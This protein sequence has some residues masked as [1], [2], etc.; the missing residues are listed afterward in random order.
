MG[1]LRFLLALSVVIIHSAP[2]LG[3]QLVSGTS[4]VQGFFIVSGF[5]M[6][7]ILNE[8]YPASANGNWLFYS[9]RFLR[10]YP[11]YWVTLSIAVLV[12]LIFPYGIIANWKMAISNYDWSTLLYLVVS[13]LTLIG[14]DLGNFLRIQGGE[15]FWTANFTAFSPAP[16]S[17]D[18]IPQA[19]TLGIEIVVYAVAPFL[20]RRSLKVLIVL[21]IMSF[22]ARAVVFEWGYPADPWSVR[23]LPFE[24]GLF[25]LG[26]I[27]YRA[28]RFYPRDTL[29]T[30]RIP[31]FA[32]MIAL[33]F[34]YTWLPQTPSVIP[35]MISS[36]AIYLGALAA[37]L[38]F[39]FS[40][41]EKSAIDRWIGNL[42]YPLYLCHLIVIVLCSGKFGVGNWIPVTGSVLL[43]AIITIAVD[44]PINRFRQ[45][46]IL[47]RSPSAISINR[48]QPAE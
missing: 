11:T 17:F 28:Y 14:I 42:S 7:M 43:A 29:R 44:A 23:F 36:Q 26:A 15:L 12:A 35:G 39:L 4:A 10:I 32:L 48:V 27:A 3:L 6:S 2:F 34:G 45:T 9:N 13:N 25:V 47:G 38:P 1:I 24:F 8:K 46:R 22:I 21:A 18:F 5:Y 19:W 37:L 31:A 16:H 33:T 30:F 20:F 40:L 41:S